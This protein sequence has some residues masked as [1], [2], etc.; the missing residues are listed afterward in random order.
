ML[1]PLR[2]YPN[3]EIDGCTLRRC[4]FPAG[5][6]TEESAS[7]YFVQV[8]RE[9][10]VDHAARCRVEHLDP[11]GAVTINNPMFANTQPPQAL[12]IALEGFDVATPR[13]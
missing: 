2:L 11:A 1:R 8:S 3:L 12:Q 10:F 9:K 7:Q 5:D 4:A 6:K 13:G